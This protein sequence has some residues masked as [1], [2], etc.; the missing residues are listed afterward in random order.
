MDFDTI[1]IPGSF[2]IALSWRFS[3]LVVE[4]RQVSRKCKKDARE[5]LARAERI[6]QL[7]CPLKKYSPSMSSMLYPVF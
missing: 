6:R 4:E 7:S 1:I 5:K 2:G 3:I